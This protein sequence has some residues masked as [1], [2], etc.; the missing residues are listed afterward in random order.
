MFK[1]IAKNSLLFALIILFMIIDPIVNS[2]LN[3]WLQD[4]FNI[5]SADEV[6]FVLVIRFLVIGFLIW[7][8]KRVIVYTS[9]VTQ[10]YIVC[11]VKND[12]KLNMFRRLVKLDSS[13]L[14]EHDDSGKFLSFFTNDINLLEQKY[15]NAVFGLISGV[16]S[17]VIMGAAFLRMNMMLGAFIV[18]FG[19]VSMLVPICFTKMLNAKNYKYSYEMSRFTLQL[20]EYLE[21]YPTIKNYAIE[22]EIEKK[23]CEANSRTKTSKFDYEASLVLSN[24]IGSMLSW[25][26]Q[27]MAVGI[28]LLLVTRGE[29]LIGTVIAARSFSSDLAMPMQTI[30]T[31]LNSI[32]SVKTVVTKMEKLALVAEEEV[33]SEIVDRKNGV[34]VE[35]KDLTVE[36]EGRAV[37][38][39]LSFVFE[40]G[41]KYLIVGKNGCGKSTMFKTLKKRIPAYSGDIL[42][43]GKSFGNITN[44]ELSLNVSYLNEKVSLFSGKVV[45]NITLYRQPDKLRFCDA[46]QKAQINI[47]LNRDILDGGV[48]I[49][50]G[51][52]RRIEVARS[53]INSVDFIVFDEVISTLDIETAYEI[54]KMILDYSDKTIV[55]I[56]H[57]FSGLLMKEYDEILY[58]SDGKIVAHGHYNDIIKNSHFKRLLK[59]KFGDLIDD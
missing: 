56:S 59:I 11:K 28:G 3:Y 8:L 29:I 6:S 26:M 53:L 10:S 30:I 31:N 40:Q 14:F 44:E 15:L 49:S 23:F 12:V 33:P 58:M 13:K 2:E 4:L 50:S 17:L 37:V 18:A 52:Q 20:K 39:G 25:F 41:K 7:I 51:E 43:N 46:I 47:D 19:M 16:F 24:N 54:E 9:S 45:D 36:Y 35:F 32:K 22:K 27:F 21:A 1:A 34:T 57:N 55:F 48:N 42:I 5:A 38:D